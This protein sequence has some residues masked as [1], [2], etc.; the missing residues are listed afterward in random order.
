MDSEKLNIAIVVV[1]YNRPRAL[2]RLL[3][4]LKRAHYGEEKIPLIVSIDYCKGEEGRKVVKAAENFSWPF[5][6]KKVIERTQNLGLKRHIL[7]CGDLVKQYDALIMLEDDLTVSPG[8]YNFAKAAAAFTKGKDEVGGVSLYKHL[9]QV[10]VR[11][12]FEP[13]DD[14]YD[15]WYFQFASS[16]GQL[17][18]KEQWKGFRNWYRRH[19][20]ESLRGDHIPANVAGWS[21]KSWLKIYIHYLIMENKYFFYPQTSYTTNFFEEGTHSKKVENDLQVP[22][23][24]KAPS[25]FSFSSLEESL[26]VYDSFFE[27]RNMYSYI[28]IK[29][30]DLTVDLYGNK[31]CTTKY[32][33]TGQCL[34][35]HVLKSFGLRRRPMEMNVIEHIPGREIFLYDMEKEGEKPKKKAGDRILYHYRGFKVKYIKEII[36]SRLRER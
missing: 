11:E 35:R 15:N 29:K 23:P 5:G 26:S 24:I 14:G 31:R 25:S 17:W 27:N 16:W 2:E 18:T 8:F 7:L 34:N 1:A 6:E 32:Y 4:S 36:K 20:G 21:H 30:E 33:L 19:G 9:F 12:P 10:H 3:C 28:G 22:M 13:I